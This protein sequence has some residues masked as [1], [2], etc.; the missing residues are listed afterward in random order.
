MNLSQFPT[1]RWACELIVEHYYPHLN[2]NDMVLEPSCG[3]GRF[4]M[5]LPREISGIGVEIDPVLAQAARALTGRR[6][7]NQDFRTLD[8]SFH[9][10]T[11]ILG[12]PPFQKD[13]VD[14]FLSKSWELLGKDQQAAFILPAY[15]FQTSQDV[16]RWKAK[17]DINSEIIPRDL[18]QGLSIP[19]TFTRFTKRSRTGRLVGFCNVL[20]QTSA[21]VKRLPISYRAI[22]RC[23]SA[24]MPTRSVWIQLVATIISSRGGRAS[25]PE[26]YEQAQT[27]RPTPNPWWREKV[28]QTLKRG[29]FVNNGGEWSLN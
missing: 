19:L 22:L 15:I 7:I 27:R 29:P 24:R 18:F 21:E 20:F 28:R 14:A 4:L 13:V 26:I 17:W 25:L 11:L 12:N 5:A 2:G 16:V 9:A 6:I 1:P 23:G 10:P 8:S 3:D